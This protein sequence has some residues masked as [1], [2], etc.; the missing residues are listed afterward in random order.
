[1]CPITDIIGGCV[2]FI[3]AFLVF[4]LIAIGTASL[5][6]MELGTQYRIPLIAN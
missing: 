6:N 5:V 1:M 3:V 2:M 4:G